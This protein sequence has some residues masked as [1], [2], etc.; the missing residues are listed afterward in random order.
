MIVRYIVHTANPLTQSHLTRYL[1]DLLSSMR[2]EL[3]LSLVKAPIVETRKHIPGDIFSL[4]LHNGCL[5]TLDEDRLTIFESTGV[6]ADLEI[7]ARFEAGFLYECA[8]WE[9]LHDYVQHRLDA[10]NGRAIAPLVQATLLKELRERFILRKSPWRREMETARI[11]LQSF[12]QRWF[13][14]LARTH[15]SLESHRS[16]WQRILS[17]ASEFV[18]SSVRGTS[19][20][21]RL[22]LVPRL[23]RVTLSYQW[24]PLASGG[25]TGCREEMMITALISYC[26]ELFNLPGYPE[27]LRILDFLA[28][29]VEPWNVWIQLPTRPIR[30][31]IQTGLFICMGSLS[32]VN[33]KI[34]E[35][36]P[37][38]PRGRRY[39]LTCFERPA[40]GLTSPQMLFSHDID[41]QIELWDGPGLVTRKW[42]LGGLEMEDLE[43]RKVDILVD[44]VRQSMELDEDQKDCMIEDIRAFPMT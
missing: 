15:R 9:I 8:S 20:G 11:F 41:P 22:S 42:A 12:V 10:L 18:D 30:H 29:A 26:A 5:Q 24:T 39:R 40:N 17:L 4:Q 6:P 14:T 7:M 44:T 43:Q 3:L 21:T 36:H 25:N 38:R 16:V 35:G 27:G 32:T 34:C 33:T 31:N 19:Q 2:L 28:Q 23:E 37:S 13:R 1:N